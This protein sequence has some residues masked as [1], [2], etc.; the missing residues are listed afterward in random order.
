MRN[1]AQ[2]AFGPRVTDPI[3][4][5]GALSALTGTAEAA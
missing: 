1:P 3:D 2:T 5:E 4:A